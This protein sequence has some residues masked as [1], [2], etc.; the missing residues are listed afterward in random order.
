M[1]LGDR[2]ERRARL[3]RLEL[4]GIA[5]Q[6][7]L[8]AALLGFGDHALHL[9][10]ADHAGF[11]DHQHIDRLVEQLAALRPLMLDAGDR[12]RRD[13]RAAFEILGGDAGQRE[14]PER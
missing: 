7:D 13:A 9:A 5:D 3:D 12:A 14:R 2:A 10:R 6:H 11:V 1:P 4:L 8:G